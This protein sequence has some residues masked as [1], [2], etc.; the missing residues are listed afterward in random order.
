MD[1]ADFQL[2]IADCQKCPT[3]FSL[4]RVALDL[5]K[6]FWCL[7]WLL[8]KT[9]APRTFLTFGNWQSE[10]DN[11]FALTHSPTHLI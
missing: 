11:V 8:Q 2:P 4:S 5:A 3:N 7:E 6:I 10:I 9:K 1:I